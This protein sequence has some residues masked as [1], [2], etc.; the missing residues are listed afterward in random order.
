M[1]VYTARYRY[2]GKDRLDVTVKGEDPL[3]RAFAPTWQMVKALKAGLMTEDD[4]RESYIRMM[5]ESY[6]LFKDKWVKLLEMEE[7]TLV[8]YCEDGAFCH[9]YILAELLVKCG[10][11]YLGER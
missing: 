2:K 4:Y 3:G 1:K 10:A 11:E 5:R 9:R 7:V 6:R 8:C